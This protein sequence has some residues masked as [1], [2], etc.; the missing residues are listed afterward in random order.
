MKV[1][2]SKRYSI[3]LITM[4]TYKKNNLKNQTVGLNIT[5][6][7]DE[8]Q[9]RFDVEHKKQAK[10]V[11]V[12][13]F[14]P[15]KAPF[16]LA[17]DKVRPEKVYDQV[18][19]EVLSDIYGEIVKKEELKP[20][21]TPKIELKKAKPGEDWE[22]ELT[23]A[24]EPIVKI[25][26][27]KKIIAKVQAEHK[28]DEL[29]T[30]GK[31]AAAPTPKELSERKQHMLNHVLE[32]L[33]NKTT[34]EI[35]DVIV[36]QEVQNRLAKL[37]DDVQKIGL[38]IDAY[39]SSKNLTKDSIQAQFRKEIMEM[40]IIEYALSKI[41]DEEKITVE[42]DDLK[43]FLDSAKDEKNQEAIKSNLYFYSTMLRKQKILDFL[44]SS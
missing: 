1:A 16:E 41:G 8:I 13:G 10:N 23:V 5:I 3:Y 24:L 27:Y 31:D 39:L 17:K 43:S 2:I 9:K 14:R 21:I 30:P 25:P 18:I 20:I 26:D 34:I 37:V 22:F 44:A 15:G 7:K 35:S 29:W 40:Y 11:K 33:V 28:K 6:K 38:T 19:Q 4:Y 32:E 42:E 36:E 12:E